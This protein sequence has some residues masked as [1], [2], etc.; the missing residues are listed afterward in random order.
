MKKQIVYEIDANGFIIGT[1]I[2][3]CVTEKT[4]ENIVC[5]APPNGLYRAKWT[6]TEWVEDMSQGEIDKLNKPTKGQEVRT[7]KKQ[8]EETDY[9]I[10][11]SSEYQLLGLE[12]PYDLEELHAER[13][14][15]RDKIN[16]LENL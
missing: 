2:I 16:E 15:L 5:I 13:Q 4:K 8:L 7:L 9:K 10:I 1:H 12:T 3:N 11:K 6:G 14:N